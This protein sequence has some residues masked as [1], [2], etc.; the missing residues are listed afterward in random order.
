VFF[1]SLHRQ[2]D[3]ETSNTQGDSV[4]GLRLIEP[5]ETISGQTEVE[6]KTIEHAAIVREHFGMESLFFD[7]LDDNTPQT[8]AQRSSSDFVQPTLL[9]P[10]VLLGGD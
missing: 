1:S 3:P 4:L 5:H 10:K 9:A 6:K 7:L 2:H 8:A